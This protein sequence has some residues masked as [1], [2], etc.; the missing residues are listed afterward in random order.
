MD[1][2]N[3]EGVRLLL[4]S[5]GYIVLFTHMYFFFGTILLHIYKKIH[6]KKH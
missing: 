6:L 5:A 1:S 3:S 2:Q 4:V